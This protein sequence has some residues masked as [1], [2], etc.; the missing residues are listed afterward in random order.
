MKTLCRLHQWILD[1][2]LDD[3]APPPGWVRRHLEDCPA[4][5][6]HQER[7]QRSLEF[8]ITQAPDRPVPAPPFLR[9]RVLANLKTWDAASAPAP[10]V[11]W[12][13]LTGSMAAILVAFWV[14][15]WRPGTG[16]GN[17]ADDPMSAVSA[18][19]A[20]ERIPSG[21]TVME[22]GAQL[23]APLEGEWELVKSDARKALTALA[24]GFTTQPPAGERPR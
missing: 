23:D 6:E 3:G 7:Q 11:G 15:V 14:V 1:C 22:L 4:C 10:R 12:W 24:R 8:L 13:T 9:Q 19:A 16:S 17:E 20:L 5:R 18:L 21:S 2:R